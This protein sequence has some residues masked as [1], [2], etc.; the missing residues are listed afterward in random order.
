[1][2][3]GLEQSAP[4]VN[5][6]SGAIQCSATADEIEG[7]DGP[8]LRLDG[9]ITIATPR[10]ALSLTRQARHLEAKLD[11]RAKTPSWP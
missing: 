8:L 7:I 11:A 2:T 6:I 5:L 4:L 3:G 10:H 9:R 1:M